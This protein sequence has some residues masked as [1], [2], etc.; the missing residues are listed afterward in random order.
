M[1]YLGW[2]TLAIII[3]ESAQLKNEHFRQI[4]ELQMLAHF[5]IINELEIDILQ[6]IINTHLK[7]KIHG[8]V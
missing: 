5:T 2:D 8:R 4:V 1:V 7:K 6:E 3:G